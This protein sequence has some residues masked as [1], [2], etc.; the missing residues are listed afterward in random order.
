MLC[1]YVKIMNACSP[2]TANYSKC[3]SHMCALNNSLKFAR[4]EERRAR[5]SGDSAARFH[6][7]IKVFHIFY[8]IFEMFRIYPCVCVCC[9]FHFISAFL[10]SYRYNKISVSGEHEMRSCYSLVYIFSRCSLS[11]FAFM[12][13]SHFCACTSKFTCLYGCVPRFK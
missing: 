11:R 7:E 3:Y 2:L 13:D 6:D 12:P 10:F 5:S 4:N 9:Y 8:L 1:V